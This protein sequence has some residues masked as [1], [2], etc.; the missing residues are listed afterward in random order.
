MLPLP[1]LFHITLPISWYISLPLGTWM[2]YLSDHIV[3]VTRKK[4]EYPSP[5]HQFIKRY[6]SPIIVIIVCISVVIVWQVLHPFSI[7]LFSVGCILASIVALHLLIV[8]INPTRHTVLNNKELAIAIIYGA[9]IY[10]APVLILYQQKISILVPVCCALLLAANAFINLLMASI[11]ELKWDEEMD[12]TSLVR[13]MGVNQSV[14]LF[15]GLLLLCGM[16]IGWLLLKVPE[17]YIPMLVTYLAMTLGHLFIY[18]KREL[19]LTH[20][21]YRKLS[22]ALFWLPVIGFFL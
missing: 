11:I 5:R 4:Q 9:G 2:I 7:L 3:D 14:K 19:L 8:R 1:A 12:N 22:E 21:A 18:Q 6:L 13:V 15:H 10:A 17:E 20:L 16:G